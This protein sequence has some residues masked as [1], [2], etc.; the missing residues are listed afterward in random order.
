MRIAYICADLGVPVFG[1]KGCSI[2]VQEVVR[3]LLRR[4]AAVDLFAMRFD[5]APPGDLAPVRL[6]ALPAPP[7]GELAA[8]ESAAQASNDALY[9]ALDRAGPFDLVYERYSLWSYRGMQY[10]CEHGTPG[11]LEVNAPLI[12]EQAAHH[13]LADRAAAERVAERVFGAAAALLAVSEQ[14]ALYLE[15]FPAARG[16]IHVVPNGVRPERFTGVVRERQTSS[17]TVGFVGSLKPRHGLPILVE[18]F[19]R[20][21]EID[22]DARLL[23][24]GDGSERARVEADLA[25]RGLREGA[26]F[27]G[28]VAPES[29]PALLAEMDVAVTP[30]PRLPDFYFSPLKVYEYM[31]AGLPVVASRIGQLD[32]L[33]DHGRTGLLCSPGDPGAMAEALIW[34]RHDLDLRAALGWAAS[35]A[36]MGNHTWDAVAGRVLRIARAATPVLELEA[37]LALAV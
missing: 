1:R 10:A 8:R 19:A 36:V 30:Y 29:I 4:G 16:R 12:E 6:H 13:S 37:G 17:F 20:L 7:K 27:T 35:T 3:A 18:A 15:R 32:G 21:R 33:I 22:A 2:H 23:I 34:L 28:A 24:V 26:H 31:A 25:R 5:G 11:L 9:E 14:L